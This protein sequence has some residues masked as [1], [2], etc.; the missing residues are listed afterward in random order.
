MIRWSVLTAAVLLPAAVGAQAQQAPLT[1]KTLQAA[2]AARPS[3]ADAEQLANRVRGYFG[4]TNI[5]RG[6]TPKTDEV[7]VAWAIEVPEATAP[8]KVV[9]ADGE[10]SLTLTRIGQTP[11]YAGVATLSDK[12]AFLWHYEVSGKKVGGGPLEVYLT[13]PDSKEQPGVPKGTVRQMPPWKSKIFEGTTRDWW[14]YVPAQY[15]PENPA[16]VMVF[17]DGQG[18][19][20]Y[21][22]TVFDNL[23]HKGDMPITVGVFINP[24]VFA[25]GR[26]NRSFEY[27][28]LSDR[29]ARMLLEEILPEVER[30]GI[31]L[32]HDAASRAIAG[33]SSGGICAFTVAWER[34]NEFSKVLSWVGSF[35]NLQPGPTGRDGGHNYPAL[36]R[37]AEK[38]PI[39]VFLQDGEN[40]LDN[41][42]GNW[43]LANQYM[44]K[45]LAFKG[46]DYKF[47]YGKGFHRGKHGQAILPDS[48]RWLWR[49]YKPQ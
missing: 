7:T 14:I 48:L 2:L 47:E 4:R 5:T 42:A 26:R 17:Q 3:G 22:P 13:H 28:S 25:D 36:I 30:N 24:G 9:S 19:K 8:P 43:P 40:D 16:C 45:S 11:V 21:V 33:S 6:A 34:P 46:Y 31:K 15:K 41:I 27:D 38:K 39:R 37:R 1:P 49:D 12:A 35:T 10:F 29:Y 44:A 23:I 32:R 20:N 18:P